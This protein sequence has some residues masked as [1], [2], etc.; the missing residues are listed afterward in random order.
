MRFL[1]TQ[2]GEHWVLGSR[3]MP[4]STTREPTP[5]FA[6]IPALRTQGGDCPLL[7]SR[8][9]SSR[10]GGLGPVSSAQSLG[11]ALTPCSAANRE[12][13]ASPSTLLHWPSE[14]GARP[15]SWEAPEAV[16]PQSSGPLPGLCSGRGCPPPPSVPL[17][18]SI[19]DTCPP[20]PHCSC[21]NN[22]AKHT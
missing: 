13:T 20:P 12:T 8:A 6:F 1:V 4:V 14:R 22:W 17:N 2:T 9:S 3:K 18:P 11:D 19:T 21:P 16:Q 10:G 15:A 5:T 7:C